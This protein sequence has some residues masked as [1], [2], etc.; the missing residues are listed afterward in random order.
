MIVGVL[1]TGSIGSRH[2][3]LL[4]EFRQLTPM[5]IPIRAERQAELRKSGYQ[6]AASLADAAEAG[7]AKLIIATD[8]ERHMDDLD[9]AIDAGMDVMIEK[10]MAVSV[11]GVSR[12]LRKAERRGRK[13]TVANCMRFEPVIRQARKWLSQIGKIHSAR[14]WCHSFLPDWRPQR[15]FR[16]SYS[17]DPA[18]GGVLR[19]L[20]HEIDLAVWMI[21][22]AVRVRAQLRNMKRLRIPVEECADIAIEHQGGAVSSIQLDYVTRTPLRG[23]TCI[24][25][26]GAVSW[27]TLRQTVQLLRGNSRKLAEKR[28]SASA[29]EKYIRQIGSFAGLSKSPAATGWEGL[30]ALEI[31][32]AARASSAAGGK[33]VRQSA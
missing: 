10:P 19:D 12:A 20:I 11:P 13:V 23:G 6:T 30:Q 32:D 26:R 22:P 25:E 2:L 28:F 16:K 5:A 21:G 9:A 17:A 27:D 15:D 1:G 24:G 7:C 4:R 3:R 8:T 14:F 29:D 31:V 33:A 18:Q